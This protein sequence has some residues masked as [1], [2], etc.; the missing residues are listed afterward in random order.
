M[1]DM[2]EEK[3]ACTWWIWSILKHREGDVERILIVNKLE[4][5][6]RLHG[7]ELNPT[8]KQAAADN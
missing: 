6:W 4:L 8:A 5:Y 3:N 7:C 2:T 1:L